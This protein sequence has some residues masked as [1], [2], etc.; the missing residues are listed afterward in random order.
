M[1]LRAR[2][3][4]GVIMR[5]IAD[6]DVISS[7]VIS[8]WTFALRIKSQVLPHLVVLVLITGCTVG[9]DFTVPEP[10]DVQSPTPHPLS[11]RVVADGKVQEFMAGGDIPGKWWR[12][13]RSKDLTSLMERAL[14][15]NHDLKSAQAALR[16]A[17]ANYEAQKGLFFPVIN[18]NETSSLKKSRRQ[19]SPLQQYPEVHSTP[20][21]PV[22]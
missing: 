3:A 5:T 7:I 21:M 19:T 4:K 17:R 16:V 12:V 8:I 14:R 2:T 9:P 10:P 13:F 20:C 1:E 6:Q 18:L 11:R 15:E 22:S